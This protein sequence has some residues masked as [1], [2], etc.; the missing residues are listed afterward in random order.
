LANKNIFSASFQK[1]FYQHKN[2]ISSA[3]IRFIR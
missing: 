3:K 1:Y 2:T